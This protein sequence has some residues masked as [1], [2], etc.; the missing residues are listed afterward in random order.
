VLCHWQ[1]AGVI[2]L[3]HLTGLD[4]VGAATVLAIWPNGATLSSAAGKGPDPSARRGFPRARRR[5]Y[6]ICW[7]CDSGKSHRL[8]W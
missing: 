3:A 4:R 5:G 8:K 6:R 2:R 7:A 1:G